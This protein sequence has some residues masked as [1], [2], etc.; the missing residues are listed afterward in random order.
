[1][2]RYCC[3]VLGF[4]CFQSFPALALA[5]DAVGS[6]LPFPPK[7][8]GDQKVVTDQSPD[9]LKAPE[10]LQPGVKIAKV[11]PQV[12]FLFYPGQDYVGNPWSNWSEG[13]AVNG[14]YYSAIGDHLGLGRDEQDSSRTLGNAFVFEYDSK[15]KSIRQLVNLQSLL[16]MPAGHY[17][18]GKIH[19]R[20]DQGSD[21][22]LYYSTHRGSSRATTPEFHYQGDWILRTNP[23][24][25]KSEIVAHG[26]VPGH[27]IPASVLDPER[28]IF[29]GGTRAGRL[30]RGVEKRPEDEQFLAF[31]VRQKKVLYAGPKALAF[32]LV[33]AQ[34]T[35]R[36]YYTQEDENGPYVVRFDPQQPTPEK[37]AAD[38]GFLG[39]ATQE[40]ADGYLYT[41]SFAREGEQAGIWSLNTKTE[42]VEY[43]GPAH[44]GEKARLIAS[45][46]IS[47]GG[48]YL[49]YTP[50]AHGGSELTGTPIVQFDTKT[51]ERKVIAFLEPFY[52][53]KYGCTLKGTY[54][55]ALDPAGDKLY[56]TWNVSRD[57]KVWDCCAMTVI[58]IPESERKE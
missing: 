47:P 54:S 33:F 4:I 13:S 42:Q 14:K 21:G 26:P 7:L 32:G 31:D 25:G 41:A 50:G 28:M 36:V 10:T 44:V 40:T 45:L 46:T 23:K 49:Y 12:D 11:A 16:N 30:T 2:I 8:P 29:Y 9:F 48:R 51:K 20:V 6:D 1:M 15:T 27:S 17:T 52:A 53:E 39:H 56:T 37:I 35:G 3:M 43:L 18:P 38:P 58:H 55:V 24:T 19:G 34:S 5:K 22:W 57:S